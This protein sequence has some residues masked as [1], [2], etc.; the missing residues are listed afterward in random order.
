MN[1]T[2]TT[3]LKEEDLLNF[4]CICSIDLTGLQE[5]GHIKVFQT[6]PFKLYKTFEAGLLTL[7]VPIGEYMLFLGHGLIK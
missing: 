6:Y 4:Y 3:Y 7:N 1:A 5:D 2:V